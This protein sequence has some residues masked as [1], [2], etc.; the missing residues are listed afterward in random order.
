MPIENFIVY[1]WVDDSSSTV[2][3]I[4]P[5]FASCSCESDKKSLSFINLLYHFVRVTGS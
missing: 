5:K 2:W 1:Y 3:V 4:R